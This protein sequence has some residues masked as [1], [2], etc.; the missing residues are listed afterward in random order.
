MLTARLH[1]IF[2]V[3]APYLTDVG[4]RYSVDHGQILRPL[5]FREPCPG[6]VVAQRLQRYRMRLHDNRREARAKPLVGIADDGNVLDS[7]MGQQDIL[8]L[9]VR[10]VLPAAQDDV[11]P[12][13][14]TR[15]ACLNKPQ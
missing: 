4:Q 12:A 6:T 1:Q 10:D 8:D 14:T 13:R 7:G 5:E 9:E 11:K 15:A 2:E 3:I